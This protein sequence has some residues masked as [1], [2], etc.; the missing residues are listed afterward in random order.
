MGKISKI[1]IVIGGAIY[2]IA[3]SLGKI[4][5]ATQ[6]AAMLLGLGNYLNI[7]Y[8]LFYNFGLA[9]GLVIIL[10][11][12]SE[13]MT[14]IWKKKY[15]QH[16]YSNLTGVPDVTIVDALSYINYGSKYGNTITH[17]AKDIWSWEALKNK[18]EEGKIC[19]FGTTKNSAK[20]IKITH[21]QMK[22]QKKSFS[23]TTKS[24]KEIKE[25][26]I[27]DDNNETELINLSVRKR[28]VKKVFTPNNQ[29][30]WLDV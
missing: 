30:W 28:D 3:S 5:D 11:I 7:T 12:L 27:V 8:D 23:F 19:F 24:R 6:G 15:L 17:D 20:H 14:F 16:F 1:P 25:V 2:A 21:N 13:V 29:G 9:T 4:S 22:K 18:F 10:Y 26:M